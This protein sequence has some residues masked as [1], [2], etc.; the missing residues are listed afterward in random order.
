MKIIRGKTLEDQMSHVDQMITRMAKNQTIQGMITPIPIS[1]YIDVP[2]KSAI[3]RYMFAVDGD[4]LIGAIY[5]EQ[6]PKTGATITAVIKDGDGVKEVVKSEQFFIDK[7]TT[8]I[9]P[10]F[11]VKAGSRLTISMS[12]KGGEPVFGIWMSLL[13]APKIEDVVIKK[14]LIGE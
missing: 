5:V 14:F 4:I 10:N 1:S 3:L 6:M 2:D 12:P 13:W 11:T 9:K 7:N 8:L